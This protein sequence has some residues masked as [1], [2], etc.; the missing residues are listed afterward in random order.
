MSD[1][2]IDPS[3]ATAAAVTAE[4]SARRGERDR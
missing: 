4:A 3:A 2:L 1:D